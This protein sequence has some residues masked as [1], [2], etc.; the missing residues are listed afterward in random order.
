ML[1]PKIWTFIPGSSGWTF[2]WDCWNPAWSRGL[3][4]RI[5][6]G[7]IGRQ[8]SYPHLA[9]S[10]FSGPK[11]GNP[12]VCGA[13][14]TSGPSSEGVPCPIDTVICE[15]PGSAKLVPSGASEVALKASQRPSCAD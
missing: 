13:V 4:N 5:D 3:L 11:V 12:K 1:L 6:Q 2:T 7:C 9:S 15:S 8:P 10:I 14:V